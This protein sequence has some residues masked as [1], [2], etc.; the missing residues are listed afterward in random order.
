MVTSETMNKG[1]RN[2]RDLIYLRS[3]MRRYDLGKILVYGTPQIRG[4][5][6]FTF[7][8]GQLPQSGGDY[9]IIS[10]SGPVVCLSELSKFQTTDRP[11]ISLLCDQL[12]LGMSQAVR[13]RI[14][15]A[16]GPPPADEHAEIASRCDLLQDMNHAVA[17]LKTEKTAEDI[18]T[19]TVTVRVL[20]RSLKALCRSIRSGMSECEAAAIVHDSLDREGA[21]LSLVELRAFGCGLPTE[22]ILRDGDLVSVLSETTL[23]NGY[24]AE[25]G[26]LIQIGPPEQTVR[27]LAYSTQS[28]LGEATCFLRVGQSAS[29]VQTMA[30]RRAHDLGFIL[31][32]RL[33]HG[34][35]IDEDL[36]DLADAG[37][38]ELKQGMM[39]ALHP[40]VGARSGGR[41]ASVGNTFVLR[42]DR[43]EPLS[44]YPQTIWQVPP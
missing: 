34:V 1:L 7:V 30:E 14:G 44:L 28:V 26:I 39:I 38:F 4:Y 41:A 33:G 36:P 27:R 43:A 12:T 9:A 6:A 3:I 8:T 29:V 2:K 24:W 16:G 40:L 35:G 5:G 32:E 10:R 31:S 37:W 23:A 13:P 21:K 25:I 22:R 17:C 20:E 18:T 19:T 42:A 11:R 15:L